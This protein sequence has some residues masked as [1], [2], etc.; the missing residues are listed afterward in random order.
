MPWEL[1]V[2]GNESVCIR[3]CPLTVEETQAVLDARG[4][5]RG[6]IRYIKAPDHSCGARPGSAAPLFMSDASGAL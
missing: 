2:E 4:T 5:G 1:L 6:V 3:M